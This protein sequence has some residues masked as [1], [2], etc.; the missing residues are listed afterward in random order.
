V[1]WAP[2]D[3]DWWQ[4]GALV[5]RIGDE[6]DWEVAKRREFQN[7][8]LIALTARR[9]GALVVTRNREDFERLARRLG[10]LVIV[11]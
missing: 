3:E 1:T 4:T 10:I 6:H 11:L 8:V 2:T 5:R 9:H 7:D